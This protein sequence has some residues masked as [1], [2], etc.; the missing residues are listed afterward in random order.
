MESNPRSDGS[1]QQHFMLLAM[2]AAV[3]PSGLPS[4]REEEPSLIEKIADMCEEDEV[5]QIP[6]YGFHIVRGLTI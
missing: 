5:F 4:F 6:P 3:P 2:M 1:G